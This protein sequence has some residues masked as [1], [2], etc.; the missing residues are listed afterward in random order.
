M[1]LYL[2]GAGVEGR[3]GREREREAK[4]VFNQHFLEWNIV[5]LSSGSPVQFVLLQLLYR[6]RGWRDGRREGRREREGEKEVGRR[7]RGREEGK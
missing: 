2:C 3:G 7:E 5:A 1:Q 4:V 6:V